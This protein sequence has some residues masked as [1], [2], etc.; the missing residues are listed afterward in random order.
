MIIKL[1]IIN[2]ILYIRVSKQVIRKGFAYTDTRGP[3]HNDVNLFHNDRHLNSIFVDIDLY[4]NQFIG[5]HF[6]DDQDVDRVEPIEEGKYFVNLD[7][8]TKPVGSF[9]RKK[10]DIKSIGSLELIKKGK[11]YKIYFD[12]SKIGDKVVKMFFELFSKQ[13]TTKG[14]VQINVIPHW[15]YV[16]DTEEKIFLGASPYKELNFFHYYKE[17]RYGAKTELSC[18]WTQGET[19]EFEANEYTNTE[20]TIKY[21]MIKRDSFSNIAS[22]VDTL[23]LNLTNNVIYYI[24][25]SKAV[26]MFTCPGWRTVII[27]NYKYE[28]LPG[29]N[30]LTR[31]T[32]SNYV[33]QSKTFIIRSDDLIAIVVPKDTFEIDCLKVFKNS[34]GDVVQSNE[35]FP[36]SIYTEITETIKVLNIIKAGRYNS[37]NLYCK[38]RSESGPH[39]Q[40][41]IRPSCDLNNPDHLDKDGISCTIFLNYSNNKVY[42][43]AGKTLSLRGHESGALTY[44]LDDPDSMSLKS[45]FK[46]IP[47]SDVNFD[48]AK[49]HDYLELTSKKLNKFTMGQVFIL[50]EDTQKVLKNIVRIYI[51]DDKAFKNVKV[52]KIYELAPNKKNMKFNCK[53]LDPTVEYNSIIYPKGKNTVFRNIVDTVEPEKIETVQFEELFGSSGITI[54]KSP[55]TDSDLEINFDENYDITANHLRPIYFICHMTRKTFA[56]GYE[57]EHKVVISVDPLYS[58]VNYKGSGIREDIF[59]NSDNQ[60][61]NG[62]I[63]DFDLN[64]DKD[65]RF[66]CPDYVPEHFLEGD[67]DQYKTDSL[68]E[69]TENPFKPLVRCYNRSSFMS[70]FFKSK[71]EVNILEKRTSVSELRSLWKFDIESMKQG[72][73]SKALCVC[74]N[75]MGKAKSAVFVHI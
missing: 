60:V 56:L 14:I 74:Y 69:D 21:Q 4:P 16:V 43:H 62:R 64:K 10:N 33:D 8:L 28:K 26:H 66:F 3:W 32:V 18:D 6:Q 58:R 50:L 27:W 41:K 5:L 12:G 47:K 75:K 68:S 42:I 35:F 9:R 55:E 49:I 70:R 61:K 31:K 54:L 34:F 1:L 19:K 20:T 52:P 63:V 2:L 72:K 46:P 67:Q 29:L 65:L 39:V 48:V 13:G 15:K 37:S 23:L 22:S 25:G 45:K 30:F 24:P 40:F 51:H 71:S 17:A 11:D 73:I 38:N 53:D 57:N 7:E 44:Y 59:S 36:G